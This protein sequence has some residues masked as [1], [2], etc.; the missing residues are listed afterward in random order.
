MVVLMG[1]LVWV[2]NAKEVAVVKVLT[3]AKEE[4]EKG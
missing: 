1:V 4:G 2:M 3:M